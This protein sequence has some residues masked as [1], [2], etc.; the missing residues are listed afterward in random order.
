[1]MLLLPSLTTGAIGCTTSA[2]YRFRFVDDGTSLPLGGVTARADVGGY[3]LGLRPF[4]HDEVRHVG[5]SGNDGLII[6]DHFPSP[7]DFFTNFFFTKDGYEVAHVTQS[8]YMDGK[9]WM[10]SSPPGTPEPGEFP[11]TLSPS[12]DHTVNIRMRRDVP[13][14]L[15]EAN[16]G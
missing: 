3:Y 11:D 10:C 6:L 13:T 15:P 1:M 9:W 8:G 5:P 14:K 4:P 2:D 12:A 7:P 16:S